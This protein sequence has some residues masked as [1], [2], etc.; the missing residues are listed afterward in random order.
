MYVREPDRYVNYSASSNSQ[1]LAILSLDG[2]KKNQSFIDFYNVND[3]DYMG[4][5]IIQSVNDERPLEII[6]LE[7]NRLWVFFENSTFVNYT[8]SNEN[9][10]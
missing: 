4:S 9:N 2:E 1:F 10:K 5:A 6:L 7:D 8:I 3:G